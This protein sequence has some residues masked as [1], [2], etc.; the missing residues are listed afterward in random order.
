MS[1]VLHVADVAGVG[2]A[3]R[4][5]LETHTDWSTS[6]LSLPD[7]AAERGRVLHS[8]G[9]VVR[10]GL[11]PLR[12]RRGVRIS[13]PDV[14]H[15]HWARFAP[16]MP[17]SAR[18]LLVHAHGSDVRNRKLGVGLHLV[19]RA[20]ERA[21]VVVA[22][23]PDLLQFLPERASVLPNPVD[24]DFFSPSLKSEPIATKPT[25][26]LFARLTELKGAPRLVEF[27]SALRLARPEV[28]IVAF[29]GGQFDRAA[30]GAG[31]RM[32]APADRVGVRNALLAADIV[33]GQ[34]H[35]GVLGLSELEAMAC[36]RPVIAALRQE[37]RAAGLPVVAS[38]TTHQMVDDCVALLDSP[39]ERREL[40]AL[41][42]RFVLEHHSHRMVARQLA[43]I[44]ESI[45]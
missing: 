38:G 19:Q 10:A 4:T 21:E 45:L 20:L 33:V 1:R 34:Q 35:L 24:S 12:V 11:T 36:G 27:A 30:Q 29:G 41:G 40:G 28:E 26:L 6:A 25:V 18:P 13:S 14:V 16:L 17:S 44:Y 43:S 31:V 42:R 39:S 37:F 32:L 5:A 7:I 3:L 15:V 8:A 9:L 22:S 23:T 2:S